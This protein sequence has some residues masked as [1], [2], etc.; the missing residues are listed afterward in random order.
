MKGLKKI[1]IDIKYLDL[2]GGLGIPY[3]AEEP[4]H[5]TEFGQALSERA[6]GASPQSPFWNLVA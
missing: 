6:Q 4:P 3:D 1:G 2:G 5:P